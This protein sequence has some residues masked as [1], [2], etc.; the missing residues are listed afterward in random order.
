MALWPGLWQVESADVIIGQHIVDLLHPFVRDLLQQNLSR[1]I[2]A[3]HRDHL[4]MLGGE[5]IR[6]RH[7][8]PDLTKQ[9]VRDV[10]MFLIADEGGPLTWPRITESAQNAFDST[11]RKLYR[12]FNQ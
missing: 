6:R 12:F 3:R 1:K 2:I 7:D 11:C 10:L 8:D 9:P 5:I 4:Q